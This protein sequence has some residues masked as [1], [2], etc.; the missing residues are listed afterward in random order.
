MHAAQS[1]GGLVATDD[2]ETLEV[3]VCGDSVIHVTARPAGA[4]PAT[5]IQPWMVAKADT[6]PG[7]AFRFSDA[8]GRTSITTARL[9]VSL[10]EM[11][12]NLSVRAAGGGELLHERANLPRTY[13]PSEA[14]GLFHI[15]DRFGPDATEA[16]YGLGQHQ[17]GMFNYRGSV[18]ELGQNNTDVAIPLVVSSKGYAILWN[19]AS[20]SY[21]DNRFPL[22][23][24]LE[25]MAAP[26]IDYYILYGPQLDSIIHEYRSLTGHVP[27]FP[28]WAYG[29]FQSKDRY[30]TQAEIL[31]IADRV[32]HAPHTHRRHRAGLVLVE[33][34]RP[35]RPGLQRRIHRRS[36]RAEDSA[37]RAHPR[38][39]LGVGHD[40]LR[41]P[42]TSSRWSQKG[43][44]DRRAR[45]S[46]T[47]P[48]P[49][50]RRVL[51]EP[52]CGQA[53]CARLGCLLARQQ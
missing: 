40:G 41:T 37:R 17:S 23:L 32:P 4:P 25:S 28:E 12:G 38:H 21:F 26:E 18:V 45:R 24:N 2:F 8:N 42:R 1:T 27:L 7:A 53:I 33:E 43:F 39:D 30:K 9:T 3:T 49:A 48:I 16:L 44:D 34:R 13:G 29:F 10:S 50:A 19:T 20:F 36:R 35:G 46:T 31:A 51:L 5:E 52:V 6:C 11:G 47:R 22:E 14:H 15:E